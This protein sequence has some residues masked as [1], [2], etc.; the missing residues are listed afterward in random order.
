MTELKGWSKIVLFLRTNLF[1]FFTLICCIMFSCLWLKNQIRYNTNSFDSLKVIR[2]RVS[3][4]VWM[5]A[6]V[7][8]RYFFIHLPN[9]MS[10]IRTTLL[11]NIQKL[12]FR[13][14]LIISPIKDIQMP[15]DILNFLFLTYCKGYLLFTGRRFY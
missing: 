11:E 1:N 12:Y 9:K 3:I 14:F 13:F 5:Y 15:L 4:N 10:I 8:L 7:G 6:S 2:A